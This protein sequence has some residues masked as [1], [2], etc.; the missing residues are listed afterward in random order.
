V[1]QTVDRIKADARQK[2]LIYPH[3]N[4]EPGESKGTCKTV[5]IAISGKID[6]DFQTSWEGTIQWTGQSMFRPHHRR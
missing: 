4:S 6:E 5:I 3:L 2:G 1:S